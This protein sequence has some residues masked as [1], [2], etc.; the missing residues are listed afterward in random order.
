MATVNCP[1]CSIAF[2]PSSNMVKGSA[3]A[4]GAATG[5]WVGSGV[6]LALGPL[7]AISGTIPGAVIGALL[8]GLGV[9]RFAKCPGCTKIF[10]I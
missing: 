7:G 5:A 1:H 8:A 4:A 9:S 3:V 2:N 10:K 6:G